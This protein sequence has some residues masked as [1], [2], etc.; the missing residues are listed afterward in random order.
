[1]DT[2]TLSICVVSYNTAELT[3]NAVRSAVKDITRSPV[4]KNNSEVI[5][6]DNA[7]TDHS[8]ALLNQYK[9]TTP[10]PIQIIKN[11]ANTGFAQANNQAIKAASGKY[12]M[13]LNSDTYVQPGAL[14]KLVSTF[15]EIPDQSTAGLV[16][17]VS[18]IDRLG[19]L[20]ACLLNADGTYQQQ[21]GSYPTL[22]SV[23][24]HW[25]ML[26]DIPLLG[27]V[28]P[29][30]QKHYNYRYPKT[31]LPKLIRRSWIAATALVLRKDMLDEVGDLDENIFMYAED[32]ELCIR[33]QDHHWDVAIHPTALITHLKSA[34]SSSK[35]AVIGECKGYIY[36]WQK[37]KPIWQTPVL[38]TV[39][40]LGILLRLLVFGTMNNSQKVEIYKAA[41]KEL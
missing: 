35:H 32:M 10:V 1:M 5:V 29:S 20:S 27:R 14:E 13:L 17:H 41:W 6:V 38:R 28:L 3:L 31:A 2:L 7:S 21:G 23:A 37:H 26:D 33:A 24:T 8:I 30:T 18:K 11:S 16:S 39:I 15:S 40:K 12:C 36:I 9:K 19:A 22:L 34:S 4:L 25:L